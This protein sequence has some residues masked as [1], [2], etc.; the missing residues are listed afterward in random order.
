[1]AGSVGHERVRGYRLETKVVGGTRE[2]G[3]VLREGHE[4]RGMEVGG[5]AR[6]VEGHRGEYGLRGYRG[7]EV[8][9]EGMGKRRVQ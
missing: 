4:G 6:L 1:M 2:G 9:G 5:R 8:W 7:E 3:G